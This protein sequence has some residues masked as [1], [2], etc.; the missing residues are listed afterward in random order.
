MVT[1][2]NISDLLKKAAKKNLYVQLSN[3]YFAPISKKGIKQIATSMSKNGVKFCGNIHS[4]G[5]SH[6]QIELCR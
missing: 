5:L 6:I 2:S 4:E 1:F 3:D